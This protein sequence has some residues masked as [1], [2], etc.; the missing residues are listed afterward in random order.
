M[1]NKLYHARIK[2]SKIK[3]TDA[4]IK[5]ENNFIRAIAICVIGS[6]ICC[7]KC[8]LELKKQ[9]YANTNVQPVLQK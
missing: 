9:S 3:L 1:N 4:E 2:Q 7:S 5:E 8:S 6:I